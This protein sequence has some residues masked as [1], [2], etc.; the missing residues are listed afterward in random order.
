M[1]KRHAVPANSDQFCILSSSTFHSGAWLNAV[2]SSLTVI[3]FDDD[4]VCIVTAPRLA[5][6][7]CQPHRCL[8]G[9][10]SSQLDNKLGLHPL[11]C[12]RS[13]GRYSRHHA[14]N[15]VISTRQASHQ[16]CSL[17]V[18]RE[19]MASDRTVSLSSQFYSGKCLVRDATCVDMFATNNLIRSALHQGQSAAVDAERRKRSKHMDILNTYEIQPVAFETSGV[20]GPATLP[21]INKVGRILLNVG[22][23]QENADG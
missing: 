4:K 22:M 18:C 12:C 7:V 8:W 20:C 14:L 13:A 19:K 9:C 6:P 2:T 5:L 23:S 1:S 10:G 16:I 17:L 15:G 21:N 11:S 3:L